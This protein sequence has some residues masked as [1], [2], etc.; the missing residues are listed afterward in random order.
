MLSLFCQR[1]RW[2]RPIR[3]RKRKRRIKIPSEKEGTENETEWIDKGGY[4]KN[5]HGSKRNRSVNCFPR[6]IIQNRTDLSPPLLSLC[7]GVSYRFAIIPAME[8]EVFVWVLLVSLHQSGP[9]MLWRTDLA[10]GRPESKQ[11]EDAQ[12]DSEKEMREQNRLRNG[13]RRD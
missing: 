8:Q 13:K 7:F 1:S 2:R 6:R 5:K 9:V 10:E 4:K 11:H 3:L 12:R